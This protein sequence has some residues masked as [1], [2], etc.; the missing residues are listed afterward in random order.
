MADGP[1]SGTARALHELSAA[2]AG[3]R[4][5]AGELTSVELTRHALD[6]IARL[7]P[8][9]HAFIRVTEESALARAA[10]ADRELET[11]VDRGPLHGIPYALKDIFDAEGV[12]TTSASRLRTGHVARADSTVERRLRAGGAVGLGK[13]TTFEFAIGG[14]SFD[15][16]VPPARNPWSDEH[17][18]S[19]SS[20]GSGAAV[21]AGLVGITV[22]SDTSGSTRGPAF[23]CGAV[24]LKPTY[25]RVSGHGAQTLS[26]TLDHF[27]PLTW[28]VAD[29]AATLQVIAGADP[30]DARTTD[31]EVPEYTAALDR[32]VAGLRVACSP[33][34]YAD[35]PLT[36]PEITARIQRALGVLDGLGAPVEEVTLPPYDVFNA[37]GRVICAAEAFATHEDD[38]RERPREF[39][40]YTYQRVM[41]GAGV[42]AADLL[43]AYDV[44]RWLT[45]RL[46]ETVF[47][48]CDVLVTVCGQTTAARWSDFPE[49]WPPPKLANDMQTIPFSVTGHPALSLPVGFAADGLPIGLQIV[50]RRFEEATVFRVAAALE[51]ELGE[52]RRR[53][54]EPDDSEGLSS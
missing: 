40:R 22:G 53:P 24:G 49:N 1:I 10:A 38:L 9:L 39:A 19:G 13:L 50:G 42:S 47:D 26:W 46:D 37:C 5:R 30:A 27:G 3:R 25:G 41:P 35:D 48:H 29:A 16:P 36:M 11:G 52:R 4:L 23:H 21:A 51:A 14:P 54:P 45:R 15:L 12:P 2:E 7:D 17:V 44:R 28:T 18:P 31:A 20:S 43:R 8:A 34:W 32:G 6:R 33:G